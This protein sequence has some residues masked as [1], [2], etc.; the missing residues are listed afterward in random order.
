M[1]E[2]VIKF[3]LEHQQSNWYREV[4]EYAIE[5][6]AWRQ[7][8]KQLGLLGQTPSRYNGLAFGNVST[9]VPPFSSSRAQRAFVIT[10][11]NTSGEDTLEPSELVLIK[12]FD[13][14]KHMACAV[15]LRAPSSET[16]SHAALYQL[17]AHLRW[18]FH[19]HSPLL[20]EAATQGRIRLPTSS[21]D[22]AYGDAAL[23]QEIGRLW[24]QSALS[25]K[26]I[27]A[28]GGHR[29]GLL[30]FGRSAGELGK[31]LLEHMALAHAR[32]H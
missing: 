20:W 31:N 24:R 12:H 3:R 22:A 17:G 19:I 32:S 1:Q 26:G 8:L 5:L 23:V 18:V 4:P 9:R 28:M 10:A 25:E 15:G 7:L 21:P 11:S 29:D 30:L 14:A 6:I 16:L 13:T 2:G 27:M